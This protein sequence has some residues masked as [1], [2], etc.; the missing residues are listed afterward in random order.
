MSTVRKIWK[1]VIASAEISRK[2]P[3]ALEKLRSGEYRAADL[4]LKVK[5]HPRVYG[6]KI[7]EKERLLFTTITVDGVAYAFVL[8]ALLDHNYD[9]CKSMQKGA[10][11]NM[12]NNKKTQEIIAEYFLQEEKKQAS[13]QTKT[14]NGKKKTSYQ[15]N[16]LELDFLDRKWLQLNE[17]Q[18]EIL[19]LPKPNICIGKAGAGK[20]TVALAMM[21]K[22]V[23]EGLRPIYITQSL[24]LK[25]EMQANWNDS[26]YSKDL[27]ED[28]VIFA[29]YEELLLV[30]NAERK[31]LDKD[32]CLEWI[33]NHIANKK[34]TD[35]TK[36][37][38]FPENFFCPQAIYAEFRVAC[39]YEEVEYLALGARQCS[40]NDAN[41]KQWIWKAW[42]LFRESNTHTAFTF[43]LKTNLI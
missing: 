28:A 36:V 17:R 22:A 11:K 33:K 27:P 16:Y 9:T 32:G 21:A 26:P 41:A 20:S 13:V 10:V 29:T 43:Y 1:D 3:Q 19:Y 40:F 24:P 39:G 37:E 6:I 8:E 30:A 34:I 18:Q 4:D 2:Y 42:Q 5:S 12:L 14:T 23:E 7:N 35:N 31:M 25:N 15:L 38:D